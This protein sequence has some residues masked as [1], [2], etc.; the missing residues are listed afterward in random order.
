MT[1]RRAAAI[2]AGAFALTAVVSAR[3]VFRTS[4]DLVLLNVTVADAA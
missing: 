2:L 4:T 1:T 3:Q